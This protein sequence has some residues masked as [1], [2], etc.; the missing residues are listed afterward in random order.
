[1]LELEFNAG[2]QEDRAVRPGKGSCNKLPCCLLHCWHEK[3]M[4]NTKKTP[5]GVVSWSVLCNSVWS[6]ERDEE[7]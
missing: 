6:W 7:A 5:P 3:N 2:R 1:M 4:N